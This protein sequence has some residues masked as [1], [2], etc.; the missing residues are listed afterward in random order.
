MMSGACRGARTVEL[1]AWARQGEVGVKVVRLC[2]CSCAHRHDHHA[3]A[4]KVQARPVD[5]VA[6]CKGCGNR[7]RV[8]QNLLAR[9]KS[10]QAEHG[11]TGAQKE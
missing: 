11:P 5:M 3:G 8:L 9:N 1:A 10:S 6:Q 7:A 2:V 4:H